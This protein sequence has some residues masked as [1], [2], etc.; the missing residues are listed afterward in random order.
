[1]NGNY[2]SCTTNIGTG[3]WCGYHGYAQ[4]AGSNRYIV[5]PYLGNGGGARGY[6]YQYCHF[7]NAAAN[8]ANVFSHE[9]AEVVTDPDLY[10][11]RAANG[12]EV[13]DICNGMYNYVAVPSPPGNC[14]GTTAYYYPQ[15]EWSNAACAC[16]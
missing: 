14:A 11:Y 16:V 3:S 7:S 4:T 1:M 6:C 5:M 9:L 15:K 12:N 10:N 8:Y 13:A 2:Y